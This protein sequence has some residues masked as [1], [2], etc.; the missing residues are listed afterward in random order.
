V[1]LAERLRATGSETRLAAIAAIAARGTADADELRAL[2]ACLAD[3][4]KAVQ[5]AAADAFAGLARRGIPVAP[6]LE[7][8]LQGTGARE[9]WG[10]AFALSRAGELPANA[11]PAVLEALG[12]DDG[13][14]RWA[15][16]GIIVRVKDR[17]GAIAALR[18]LVDE[19]DAVRRRMALYCLRD[20]GDRSAEVERSIVVA[21][22]DPAWEVRL[23]AVSALAHLAPD[24]VTAAHHLLE[25]L[26]AD[27]SRV[28]RAAA[29]AL[30]TLGER[31]P[32]VVTGLEAAARSDDPSLARAATA[33]LGR[34]R[35]SSGG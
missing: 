19:A 35:E 24:P 30:G 29:I 8:A 25:A 10:A 26:R 18:H 17:A 7:Q 27:D 23:A 1:T 33:A 6:V 32:A 34:L 5:R 12:S 2:A 3:E 31:S 21:L 22:G 14:V 4:R 13:D 16:A 15:A 28:R 20:L 11:L 9:R